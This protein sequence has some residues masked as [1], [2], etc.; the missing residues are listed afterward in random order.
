MGRRTCTLAGTCWQR[1]SSHSYHHDCKVNQEKK[2]TEMRSAGSPPLQRVIKA[3]SQT[4]G[5]QV[6]SL[7][8]ISA[9]FWWDISTRLNGALLN[10]AGILCCCPARSPLSLGFVQVELLFSHRHKG[11]VKPDAAGIPGPGPQALFGFKAIRTRMLLCTAP[12]C[13]R[14]LSRC[15][16]IGWFCFVV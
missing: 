10:Q 5:L 8:S 9:R 11:Q 1:Y 14:S 7:S 6:L 2:K 12:Q 3:G 13:P 15:L 4:M 16:M